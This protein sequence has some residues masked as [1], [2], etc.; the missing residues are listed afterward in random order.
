MNDETL[1]LPS[2]VAADPSACRIWIFEDQQCFRELLADY[3]RAL[4]GLAVEVVGTADDEELLFAA[5]DAGRVDVVLLDLQLQGAGGFS[6][7][8][9]LQQRARP[10]A[11]LILS[12]QATTHSVYTALRLGAVGYLQKTAQLEELHPAL[13]RVRRGESYFSEGPARLLA[14]GMA[15]GRPASTLGELTAREVDL[16]TRLVHGTAIKD[17]ATALGLTCS[18]VYKR[19]AALM[20][21]IHAQNH[22]DIVAYAM[23]NGLMNPALIQ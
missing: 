8:E 16:L 17:I 21:E 10:P 4:P 9:K 14:E 7:L 22:R 19:R 15:P 5:V 23:S 20:H 12:G 13:E 18:T 1:T 3:L 11:V 2:H 6:I